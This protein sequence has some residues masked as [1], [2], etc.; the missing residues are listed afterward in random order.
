MESYCTNG[1]ENIDGSIVVTGSFL[2]NECF[3]NFDAKTQSFEND[4]CGHRIC[5]TCRFI[6]EV[7]CKSC[8]NKDLT[9]E[10]TKSNI[11]NVTT[12]YYKAVIDGKKKRKTITS[13]K[14]IEE[15]GS[16]SGKYRCTICNRETK[17]RNISYHFTC[18]DEKKPLSCDQ[19]DKTFVKK[20]HLESHRLSHLGIKPYK[21]L[22]CSKAFAQRDKLNRHIKTHSDNYSF[23]C[24]NCDKKFKLKED[25]KK[26]IS[27]HS[28]TRNFKC[29]Q[30]PRSYKNK[31]NLASHKLKHSGTKNFTCETCGRVF[32][33]LWQLTA[34]H[35]RH[36]NKRP[37]K[38]TSCGKRFFSQQNLKRHELTH[39]EI[40]DFEC[41]ICNTPFK[42]K[43]NLE[44]HMKNLHEEILPGKTHQSLPVNLSNTKSNDV[45]HKQS[46]KD[47]EKPKSCPTSVIVSPRKTLEPHLPEVPKLLPYRILPP[48]ERFLQK[49]KEKSN[50]P[51]IMNLKAMHIVRTSDTG[52]ANVQ[53]IV[54]IGDKINEIGPQIYEIDVQAELCKKAS[55]GK[56]DKMSKCFRIIN[57]TDS[58]LASKMRD[59][60][61]PKKNLKFRKNSVDLNEGE[62]AINNSFHLNNLVGRAQSVITI[63]PKMGGIS[64]EH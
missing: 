11:D 50:V 47:S 56:D 62:K 54:T 21:C 29:D 14:H 45:N 22:L 43:D 44:R 13:F 60:L 17:Q 58:I 39:S 59:E 33:L 48:D 34:H 19:C 57:H 12:E 30:C 28:E 5:E 1:E 40:F 64:E 55:R 46:E 8:L 32:S 25:L 41:S 23:V 15:V 52:E 61:V 10:N 16:D 51:T 37:F 2:C 53:T 36:Q 9:I 3:K 31:N 6:Q 4:Y 49:N 26:H 38:C 63:A 42:R 24:D 7:K 18:A 20:S 27:T 35:K